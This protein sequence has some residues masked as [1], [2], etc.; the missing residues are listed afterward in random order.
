MRQ[1]ILAAIVTSLLLSACGTHTNFTPIKP[2]NFKKPEANQRFQIESKRSR[3]ISRIAVKIMRKYDHNLNDQIDY[4]ETNTWWKT[5]IGRNEN[6][7]RQRRY[8]SH[9]KE[10][11]FKSWDYSKLFIAADGDKDGVTSTK[12]IE[13]FII[14]AYDENTDGI[15]QTRGWWRFWRSP[16]E[17]E[18]FKREMN[19]E[20]KTHRVRKRFER[21]ANAEQEAKEAERTA[22]QHYERKPLFEDP[23][24]KK[25]LK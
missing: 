15:L 9:R 5:F 7:R 19:E 2:N 17:W 1:P 22:P 14:E 18:Y 3:T 16:D 23:A 8:S 20:L 12:E 21:P 10:W 6:E 24:A 13:N 25:E 4:R 11:T